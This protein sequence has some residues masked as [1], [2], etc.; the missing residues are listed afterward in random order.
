MQV[1]ALKPVEVSA[2]D[3]RSREHLS[4]DQS[5]SVNM[6]HTDTER[7]MRL[8]KS[9]KTRIKVNLKKTNRLWNSNVGA[10]KGKKKHAQLPE[11][12][13][14]PLHSRQTRG[15]RLHRGGLVRSAR[16]ACCYSR[17]REILGA[18]KSGICALVKGGRRQ[19]LVRRGWDWTV[20]QFTQAGLFGGDRGALSEL[21][22]EWA[23][24]GCA[25]ALNLC[26]WETSWSAPSLESGPDCP[27]GCLLTRGSRTHPPAWMGCKVSLFCCEEEPVRMPFAGRDGGRKAEERK[28]LLA[29][30]RREGGGTMSNRSRSAHVSVVY[31][32]GGLI[33]KVHCYDV[34]ECIFGTLMMSNSAFWDL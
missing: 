24:R 13:S 3:A 26:E 7:E 16:C 2:R 25:P 6:L 18:T 8:T 9:E 29:K 31:V 1:D 20:L 12:N 28:Q 14:A 27:D 5:W 17:P 32:V 15:A 4:C 19:Q 11:V 22:S 30:V 34:E 10:E 21:R 23:R 33:I